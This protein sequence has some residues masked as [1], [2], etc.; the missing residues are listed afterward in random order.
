MFPRWVYAFKW[1][2]S[3]RHVQ[4][5]WPSPG[6]ILC[7][8]FIYACCAPD[9]WWA[10]PWSCVCVVDLK[11]YLLYLLIIIIL[12]IESNI[13]VCYIVMWYNTFM[14]LCVVYYNLNSLKKSTNRLKGNTIQSKI[15]RKLN[16]MNSP[17][18]PPM[19]ATNDRI[20]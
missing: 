20:G 18:I 15:I 19:S 10:E 11:I 4:F 3:R 13:M 7:W 17:K 12:H 14:V 6:L 16:P 1:L 9:N 5:A 8:M 2:R